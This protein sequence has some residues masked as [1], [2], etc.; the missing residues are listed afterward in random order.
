[1]GAELVLSVNPT[2]FLPNGQNSAQCCVFGSP[3]KADGVSRNLKRAMKDVDPMSETVLQVQH[4]LR[5]S[6]EYNCEGKGAAGKI[7]INAEH[8]SGRDL[9]LEKTPVIIIIFSFFP[10]SY[11]CQGVFPWSTLFRLALL[12]AKG[13]NVNS[14]SVLAL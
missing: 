10:Y 3:T 11:K 6:S 5:Q 12:T 13:H 7:Q 8:F 1:M 2:P 14:V 9:C 4:I